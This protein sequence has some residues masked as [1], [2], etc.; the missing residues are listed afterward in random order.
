MENFLTKYTRRIPLIKKCLDSIGSGD[1]Y[2][3]C[4]FI[5]KSFHWNKISPFFEGEVTLYER[6]FLAIVSFKRR[7]S[8]NQGA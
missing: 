8:L 2:A 4:W 6:V 3:D 1:F 7:M 5:C